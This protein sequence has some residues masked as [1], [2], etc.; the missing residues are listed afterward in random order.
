M[1]MPKPSP[2]FEG[3]T[4]PADFGWHSVSRASLFSGLDG[5]TLLP[6][7]QPAVF[8]W[9]IALAAAAASGFWVA[10]RFSRSSSQ[11]FLGGASL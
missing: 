2:R 10:H 6:Q 11:R 4:Q 3:L 1:K 5:T 9:H 7:Q 8:G